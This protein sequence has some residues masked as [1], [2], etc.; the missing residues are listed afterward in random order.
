[1]ER[2]SDNAGL[3][4]IQSTGYIDWSSLGSRTLCRAP[5]QNEDES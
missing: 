2:A 3:P 1:M 4:G 5:N